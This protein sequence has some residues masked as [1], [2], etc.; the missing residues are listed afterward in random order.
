VYRLPEVV[1]SSRNAVVHLAAHE[2][3]A[4]TLRARGLIATALPPLPKRTWHR[5]YAA[6]FRARH[7]VVLHGND[8][9]DT[10]R[11]H[12]L[13]ATLDGIAASVAPRPLASV[14]TPPGVVKP[15]DG[16]G[17]PEPT[18]TPDAPPASHDTMVDVQPLTNP[19]CDPPSKREEAGQFL[20]DLLSC[21]PVLGAEVEAQAVAA[22]IKRATL[23]RAQRD[24]GIKA[25]RS[26][27]GA[28]LWVLPGDE[29]R[30]QDA[31]GWRE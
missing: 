17:A 13:V 7:M 8:R 3:D 4:D 12:G 24:L 14:L 21:G 10:Q 31:Q 16:V 6:A 5:V 23:R 11:A 15:T 9:A 27:G 30:T 29:A 22:G 18:A 2:A 26:T 1:R 25:K 28:Y 19:S 20:A